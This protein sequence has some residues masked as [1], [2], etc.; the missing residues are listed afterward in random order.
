MLT[1]CA[2]LGQKNF[3]SVNTPEFPPASRLARQCS[4]NRYFPLSSVARVD[5]A[6]PLSLAAADPEF[7]FDSPVNSAFFPVSLQLHVPS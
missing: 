7:R 1:R 3:E 2:V 5:A 4:D 6:F